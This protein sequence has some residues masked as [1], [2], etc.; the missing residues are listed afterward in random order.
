MKF[1][2]FLVCYL[3]MS[4]L[5]NC[6]LLV[7]AAGIAEDEMDVIVHDQEKNEEINELFALRSQM[8]L[9]YE[10]NEAR[11]N[12]IDDQLELLG[13]ENISYGEVL[14]KLGYDAMPLV[15][16]ESTATTKWTSRRV[17]VTY[18]GKQFEL[19]ILEGV[20]VSGSSPLRKNYSNVQYEAKGII[21]GVTAVIKLLG[22]N[23]LGGERADR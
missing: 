10:A 8:E 19:Q 11:I 1:R 9:D 17:V 14:D 15:D 16:F 3:V 7:D 20:P 2:R 12:Q 21:A 5:V 4:I 22:V 23:A 18:N 6:G 13:V